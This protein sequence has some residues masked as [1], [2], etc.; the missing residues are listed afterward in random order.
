MPRSGS[1]AVTLLGAT[2]ALALFF[3]G[4]KAETG[5]E[6]LQGEHRK[7][8][9]DV[10][11]ILQI[12]ENNDK[13][14]TAQFHEWK[15]KTEGLVD[16]LI[17]KEEEW[18]NR[19]D[20]LVNTLLDK[21]A[22]WRNRTEDFINTLLEKDAGWKNGT[23]Q[24]VNILQPK[25]GCTNVTESLVSTILDKESEWVTR[26]ETLIQDTDNLKKLV[27]GLLFREAESKKKLIALTTMVRNL[28]T[29]SGLARCE[30]PFK[31]VPYVGCIFLDKVG[32][33]FNQ[34][35]AR[36]QEMGADIYIAATVKQF[37]HL[38][39][40][41][42]NNDPGNTD[43]WVGVK[44]GTWLNGRESD[45]EEWIPGDPDDGIAGCGH[46]ESWSHWN[47][48]PRR[49]LLTDHMCHGKAW[50]VCQRRP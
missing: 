5:G 29:F 42:K 17:A 10:E 33:T 1:A 20:K 32:A 23:K 25:E 15:N 50:T 13:K 44:G 16:T 31:V 39:R 30:A 28:L 22:E 38:S 2:M 24:L 35:R 3:L 47:N 19:T 8:T 21:D 7:S 27:R 6:E 48:T 46:L 14:M 43:I 34:G 26:S 40:Y 41:Y 36:C 11:R 45:K 37:L 4:G 18:K 9:T 49:F 12:L